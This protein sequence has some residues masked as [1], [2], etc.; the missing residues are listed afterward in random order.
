MERVIDNASERKVK[1]L[2]M[3]NKIFKSKVAV[4]IFWIVL[5]VFLWECGANYIASVKKRFPEYVWPHINQIVD[6]ILS[7]NKITA[8]QTGTEL[9][10]TNAKATFSRAISGYLIG[11]GIGFAIALV[12]RLSKIVEKIAFPYLVIIQ[13]IPILGMAPVIYCVTN[14]KLDQ[15]RIIIAAILTFYPVAANTLSG[16]KAVESEKYDLMRMCNASKFK[17]YTK[18]LIPNCLP[19][20]F[21]GMKIAAPMAITAA[22]L[23]DTLGSGGLGSA[24]VSSLGGNP[25]GISWII[26]L[27]SAVVGILSFHIIGIIELIVSPGEKNIVMKGKR[28]LWKLLKK[29]KTSKAESL[30]Q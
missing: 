5:L 9:V 25:P 18:T 30:N 4:V 28:A 11:C 15:S 26:I 6:S 7:E 3:L 22:I 27:V 17:L 19:Y 29:V 21:T 1:I 23:V 2:G 14:G 8:T 24:L 16:L 20:L 12:M 13:M 10:L